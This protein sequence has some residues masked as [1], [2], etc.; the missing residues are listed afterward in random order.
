[1]NNISMA[2]GET[3]SFVLFSFVAFCAVIM[4]LSVKKK[5][6]NS[7]FILALMKLWWGQPKTNFYLFILNEFSCFWSMTP[8]ATQLPSTAPAH[9]Q[10]DKVLHHWWL[11]HSSWQY[12]LA[13]DHIRLGGITLALIRLHYSSS[14]TLYP[15][16]ALTASLRRKRPSK[17]AIRKA[18]VSFSL[19]PSHM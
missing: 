8:C 4:I 3:A 17:E 12:P 15:P 9:T 1:M 5:I 11:Q 13:L 19:T 18:G 7:S 2:G 10:T 14:N 16:Y 6:P